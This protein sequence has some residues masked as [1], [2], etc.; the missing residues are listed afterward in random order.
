[1]FKTFLWIGMA[2]FL[3][4]CQEPNAMD[5]D[6]VI[7]F[8]GHRGAR[9]LLPENTIPAFQK[10]LTFPAIKTLELDLAVSK[11]SQL[12]VSH[13][14]WMNSLFCLQPDGSAISEAEEKERFAI[15]QMNYEEVKAFDCGSKGNA[16][17]P[18]QVP[19]AT[20]KPTLREMV[21]TVDE[22]ARANQLPLPNYNI[23]IKSEPSWD[24]ILCPKPQAFSLMVVEEIHALGI[25]GRVNVQSFDMRPLREVRT[26]DR[27]IPLAL[28]V[29]L[30]GSVQDYLDELG[31]TPEIYSPNHRMVTANVVKEVHDRRMK[32]IPWTVNTTELMDSLLLMGVDGIIT[33]YPNRIP[34]AY[35]NKP[36]Q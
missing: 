35:A 13:E 14:P 4:A 29:H 10:A 33:D 7:D 31:F 18:E 22:Y 28:L 17:F 9:G 25:K 5:E 15:F 21:T 6:K 32:I 2:A 27:E 26:L 19:M 36:V 1:M 20:Y 23:E 16:N 34:P 8:Q 12:V 30:P 3:V 24:S 11:D